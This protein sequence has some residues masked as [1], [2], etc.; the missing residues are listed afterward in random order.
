M[1]EVFVQVR[2]ITRRCCKVKAGE[3]RERLTIKARMSAFC[4][5]EGRAEGRSGK[6][7]RYLIP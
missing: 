1:S 5:D 2:Q 3:E 6:E 4:L 7:E